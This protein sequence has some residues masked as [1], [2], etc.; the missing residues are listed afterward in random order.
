MKS[1]GIFLGILFLVGF[2]GC[3]D[4]TLEQHNREKVAYEFAQ[5]QLIEGTYQGDVIAASDKT[6]LGSI[7]IFLEAQKKIM[8]PGEQVTSTQ[9]ASLKG[10]LTLNAPIRSTISFNDGFY[11]TDRKELM[12]QFPM[13]LRSSRVVNFQISGKFIDDRL[14]GTIKILE[15]PDQVGNFQLLKTETPVFKPVIAKNSNASPAGPVSQ[16]WIAHTDRIRSLVLPVYLRILPQVFSDSEKIYD[17]LSPVKILDV[18]IDFGEVVQ[19]LFPN[20]E[21][22]WR[23]GTLHGETQVSVSSAEQRRFVID[24]VSF[25]IDEKKM[26]WNC[27]YLNPAMGSIIPLNFLP[28]E[29]S[30]AR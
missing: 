28:T 18:A 1:G 5:I 16:E 25:Q 4:R 27:N 13:T 26:G 23:R 22:D 11:D 12:L 20:A 21:W 30:N 7:S 17:L 6:S 24:C 15:Y 9:Q 29:D 8:N 2:T 14:E 19:I 10:T 3:G